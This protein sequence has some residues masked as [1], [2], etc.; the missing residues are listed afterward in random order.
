[1]RYV[2]SAQCN[3][4]PLHKSLFVFFIAVLSFTSVEVAQADSPPNLDMDIP[5][6]DSGGAFDVLAGRFDATFDGVEDTISAFNHARRQEEIQL[7]LTSGQ[8]GTFDLPSQALWNAF[9][10]AEKALFIMNQERV[11]RAVMLPNVIGRPLEGLEENISRISQ[12]YAQYLVDTDNF[13][14]LAD[15]IGPAGRIDNDTFLG[16][17][18]EFLSRSE[19]LSAFWSSDQTPLYLERSFYNWL[20]ANSNGA[21]K[22]REAV[23]LQD[24]A[25]GSDNPLTGFKDNVGLVGREGFIGLGVIHSAD[26][27]PYG[28]NAEGIG[29]IVVLNLFD[30]ASDNPNCPWNQPEDSL[31]DD[32][33]GILNSIECSDDIEDLDMDGDG[34]DNCQDLDSDG[35]GLTDIVES[36][37]SEVISGQNNGPINS[38]GDESPDYLD[39]DSDN[40][41]VWDRDEGFDT[42]GNGVPNILPSNVDRDRNG[43][44]DAYEIGDIRPLDL[45]G[46]GKPNWRDED[47]DG[48][49]VPTRTEIEYADPVGEI[50]GN[51]PSYLNSNIRLTGPTALEESAEPISFLIYFPIISD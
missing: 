46:D 31:D 49:G 14:H 26:Y 11:D 51:I 34:F 22:H 17:C 25:L 10:D 48:D 8:L 47:D 29:T 30:P 39:I 1:M 15:G 7:G 27:D 19:N 50:E 9:S 18:H 44:D 41:S 42:D 32:G 23:L 28:A 2:A 38:D 45:D 24:L 43:V 6:T 20:Y 13:D 33:D 36:Q 21:W 4:Y 40:D 35:D 12:S 3:G 37:P 16:E 5:W